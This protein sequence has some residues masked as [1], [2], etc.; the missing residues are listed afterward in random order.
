MKRAVGLSVLLVGLLGAPS[1]LH[2]QTLGTIAGVVKDASD[3]VLPGVTVEASSPVLIEKTRTVVSEGNGQF[4]IVNLPPGTYNVSFS[5]TGFS[6]VNREALVV[7]IGVT[8]TLNIT[9]RVGSV[10]ETVIVTGETPVVD[11][12]STM[13]TT[14]ADARVF[15]ELPT[16]GSW[17]NVAQLIPSVNS[18]F[19]GNR[20]VGGLQGDQTGTQVSVHGGLAGDGVSMIDGMRIGNMYLSSNLTNMSLSP[21]LYD[22]VNISFSG[23]IAESGTNGVLMNAIP[24]SG[25]NTFSGSFLAN[26]SWPALQASNEGTDKLKA[27][28]APERDSLKTLYDINGAIGG[29]IKKD[30]LWFYYTSR[31]FTNEYYMAGQYYPVDPS[32]FVRTPDLS[33]QAF[34]GTWTADNNIRL[35]WAPTAKQ[36]VSGWYA[37][38]RKDDPHWLQQ[39][40][41][42]SP[43][44][45]QIVKWPTQLST[46]TWTYT[47]TNRLLFEAGIAPGASPDTITQPPEN[48]AGVPVFEV[49]GADVPPSFANR[50][51][52]FNN[53]DDHLP[54]QTFK[55]SMSY[56]KG[57]HN[58][59]VGMQM[60]R[61]HFTRNDSNHQLGDY[62]ILSIDGMV[63]FPHVGLPTITSPLAGWTDRLNYNLGLYGQDSWTVR[64]LTLNAGVRFDF[65]NESVDAYHYGPGPWLPN[66]NIDY[67]EIKNVPNWKDVNPRVNAA[68]DLF[69]NGKTAIKG[70]VSRSVRQDSIGI[71]QANDPAAN[72]NVTSTNRAWLDFNNDRIP[73]CDLSNPAP[74]FGLDFCDAWTNPNFGNPAV[75][76]TYDPKIMNGWGVRPYNWE[77][78][79]SV[80]H[81]IIP[82]LSVSAGYFRRVRGNFWV[83]D[84]EAVSA[85]DYSYYSVTVP[86]DARLPNSGQVISGLPDLNPDKVG[87]IHNVVKDASQFG[88]QIEHWDGFDITA[89]G[90]FTN[91]II[92][93]GVSSGRRL[94]DDCAV[95]G[96]VPEA[97]FEAPS[98]GLNVIFPF[99][100][101]SEPMLTQVKG[102]ASYLLPWWDIR[103]SGTLQS[104]TGPL[105][106]AYN[107]YVGTG[108]GLG[109]PFSGTGTSSVN[110]ISGFL[111]STPFGTS[112]STLYGDRLNQ[113]DLRFTKI[114]RFGNRGSIDLNVDLYNAF[115]SDAILSAQENYGVTWQNALGVIQPRFV[116]FQVRWD[117]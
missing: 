20:D 51:S 29:P 113:V 58:L 68:Y 27:R 19:F 77:Y 16:G 74:Q 5:L 69:G 33:R 97:M 42:E 22:E 23:Q 103:V 106:A 17:V 63:P 25:G 41:F 55:G 46:I 57:S 86:N 12:R 104:V 82:R 84:N 48:I 9:M 30:A 62:Y 81:E 2:A 93:G 52:W 110:L 7:S 78:S 8:V 75:A 43:E 45:A 21:L 28:G 6:T 14:V 34:A 15:K 65:Q 4:S 101:V 102:S 112:S 99:C 37:Y 10:A 18:A 96:K 115:N 1:I 80:Q 85:S 117:F 72:P 59:K 108:D 31:Y 111:D 92:Q 24:K 39:I 114:L 11:L 36:K 49:G 35:T 60:Q 32:A 54:S 107:T 100:Q 44:A 109:R 47:A 98:P 79:A 95:V 67:P 70:S 38:Q 66:R 53:Y 50:A 91:L 3:A 61:G 26:G 105:V 56:V 87:Q 83:T 73:N 88:N 13:H 40:L 116:K 76:T 94:T 71:A 64:R 89:T 90:R